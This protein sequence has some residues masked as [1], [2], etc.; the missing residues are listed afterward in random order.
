MIERSNSSAK[1]AVASTDPES[2]LG[3]AERIPNLY[4]VAGNHDDIVTARETS[5]FL[6]DFGDLGE[7]IPGLENVF[8]LRGANPIDRDLRVEGRDWWAEEELSDEELE[9]A[10]ALFSR[11]RPRVML[12]HDC[13]LVIGHMLLGADL[14]PSRT[15]TALWRMLQLHEP[16]R[17]YFGHHHISWERQIGNTTFRCLAMDEALDLNL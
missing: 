8:F 1:C 6:G 12:S 7:H 17:W 11:V 16:E 14:I 3:K 9:E 13:P 2:R 4:V 5:I 15:A 10:I